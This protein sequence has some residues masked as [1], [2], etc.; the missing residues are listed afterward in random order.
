MMLQ[1]RPIQILFKTKGI[2]VEKWIIGGSTKIG[3]SVLKKTRKFADTGVTCS[4]H[5][6]LLD[7]EFTDEGIFCKICGVKL[8]LLP[9][10]VVQ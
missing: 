3:S 10:W 9:E 7:T 6:N 4:E 5:E 2:I 8:K 1:S